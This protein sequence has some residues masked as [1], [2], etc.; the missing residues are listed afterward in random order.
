VLEAKTANGATP[1][2]WACMGGSLEVVD[3]L[4]DCGAEWGA[5][6]DLYS[7]SSF[8]T[9]LHYAS[10]YGHFDVVEKLAMLS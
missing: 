4:L 2:M 6:S 9:P 1:L 10:Y 7:K 5:K 8:S 3:L